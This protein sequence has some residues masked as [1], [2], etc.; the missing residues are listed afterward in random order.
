MSG[1]AKEAIMKLKNDQ[2][3]KMPEIIVLDCR[4]FGK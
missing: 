3:A 1:A 4:K 2:N